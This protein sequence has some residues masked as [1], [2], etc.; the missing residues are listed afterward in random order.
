MPSF[1]AFQAK[2]NSLDWRKIQVQGN[3]TCSNNVHK[4]RAQRKMIA[5][6]LIIRRPKKIPQNP[7]DPKPFKNPC[8]PHNQQKT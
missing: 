3:E 7:T 4:F 2:E 5:T 8:K 1:V 6:L